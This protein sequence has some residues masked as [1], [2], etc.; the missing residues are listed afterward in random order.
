MV[1]HALELSRVVNC[2]HKLP[3]V[4]D[5]CVIEF[6]DV[7]NMCVLFILVV[8]CTVII[9]LILCSPFFACCVGFMPMM[10]I[11]VKRT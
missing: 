2:I 3:Y 7:E 11:E 6:Y 5:Y 10:Q 1:P 9:F 4:T 8:L